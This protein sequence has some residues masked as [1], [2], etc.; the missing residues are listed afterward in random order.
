MAKITTSDTG[1][2]VARVNKVRA[3]SLPLR[4]PVESQPGAR[5]RRRT[6]LSL[7][8]WNVRTLLDRDRTKRPERQTA[9]VAKELS[10]Y[11]IDIAALC[12]TRLSESNS[13][14][15]SGYTFLEWKTCN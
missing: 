10:R 2:N 4:H 12:E 11:D 7:A 6:F 13:I 15:D 14:V 8:E 9:L 3:G 1:S 5:R